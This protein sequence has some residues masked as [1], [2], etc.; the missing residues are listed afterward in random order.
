MDDLDRLSP[1]ETF[2]VSLSSPHTKRSYMKALKDFSEFITRRRI[3]INEVGVKD[4][5]AY[6]DELR[7]KVSPATINQRLSALR[8]AL[9]DLVRN[10]VLSFNPA[11]SVSGIKKPTSKE[12]PEI[13]PL[14]LC[15]FYS[16]IDL[17]T[18]KGRRDRL[19]FDLM[20]ET[21]CRVGALLKITKRDI[22]TRNDQVF[23]KLKEKNRR[24]VIR[25]ISDLL[26]N[27]LSSYIIEVGI[28]D[29]S[30]TI[31]RSTKS[32]TEK[33]SD[34]ALSQ[35][36]LHRIV[37]YYAKKAEI[38][39]AISPHSFRVTAITQF[40]RKGGKIQEAQKNAGHVSV[41]T[42]E[43]YDRRVGTN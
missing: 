5:E 21:Y 39:L 37:R 11:K 30:K 25:L 34:I 20:I 2:F 10:G 28:V 17:N 40:L 12:T 38:N 36:N 4:I 27:R 35:S 15:Q 3:L 9:D 23:I 43:R 24:L 19:M 13:T 16:V 18:L 42:T 8:Q 41:R 7:P 1:L 22:V 31:F 29:S 26:A 33:C 32:K 6:R 14:E